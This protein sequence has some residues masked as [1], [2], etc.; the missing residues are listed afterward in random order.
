MQISGSAFSYMV[1]SW[2]EKQKERNQ[3]PGGKRA[4]TEAPAPR[5]WLPW[6]L[7]ISEGRRVREPFRQ[8]IEAVASWLVAIAERFGNWFQGGDIRQYL[9]YLFVI[10]IVVLLV[11][12]LWR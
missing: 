9:G 12:V 5:P 10:F 8:G 2:L 6:R 4:E 11:A 7:P 1:W 3:K